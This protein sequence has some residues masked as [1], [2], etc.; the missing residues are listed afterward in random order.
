MAK[1]APSIPGSKK[2][3]EDFLSNTFS[4]FNFR[5]KIFV[6]NIFSAKRPNISVTVKM[7][8]ITLSVLKYI[9]GMI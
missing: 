5:R 2:V 6:E 8:T 9:Q 1:H 7:T 4:N 3:F